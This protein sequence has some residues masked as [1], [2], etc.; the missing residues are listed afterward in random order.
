MKC[1]QCGI[2]I[3][4]KALI[5][6]KCGTATT[7]AKFAPVPIHDTG[8]SRGFAVLVALVVLLL[9]G[10]YVGETGT[11]ETIRMSG[12]SVAVAAVLGLAGR[13]LMGRR[14]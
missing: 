14:P 7:E 6:Y 4:E 5:C 3:A 11:T 10:V 9:L 8:R 12:W 13:L 2:E 1:R